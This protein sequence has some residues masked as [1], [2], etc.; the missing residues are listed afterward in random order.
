MMSESSAAYIGADAIFACT[1]A[2]EP[3]R[4]AVMNHPSIS[5][6]RYPTVVIGAKTCSCI[7]TTLRAGSAAATAVE[8]SPDSTWRSSAWSCA[9]SWASLGRHVP[10]VELRGYRV[11]RV[12]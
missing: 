1:G 3:A 11:E 12:V 6:I 4:M 9:D 2:L 10:V 7:P 8:L 5:L